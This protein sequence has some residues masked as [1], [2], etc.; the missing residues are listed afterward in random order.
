MAYFYIVQN[1]LELARTCLQDNLEYI[2]E[3]GKAYKLPLEHNIKNLET[4]KTVEW[5]QD[6]KK[7]L[8]TVFILESRFW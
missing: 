3:A 5:F 7:Y 2:K 8:C 1:E 6:K 4:I